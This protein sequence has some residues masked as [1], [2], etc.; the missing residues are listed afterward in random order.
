[1]AK[2]PTYEELKRKVEELEEK[3]IKLQ[4][5]EEALRESEERFML[6]MDH[7]PGVVFMKDLEG[8]YIFVNKTYER[9]RGRKKEECLGKGDEQLWPAEDA[10][11]FKEA[12]GLVMSEGHS[13]EIT[14][15]V[16]YADGQ[17]HTQMTYKF[18]VLKDGK[19]SFVAGIGLDIT[20]QVQAEEALE[21]S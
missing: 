5:T 20:E 11:R 2:K 19:P 16:T 6:F 8:R 10:A 1:M 13:L 14:E 18:P 12:D 17:V 15:P 9:Q 21:E 3:T 7:F 4:K